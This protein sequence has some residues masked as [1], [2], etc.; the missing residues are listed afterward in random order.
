MIIE[1]PAVEVVVPQSSLN[2]FEVHSKIV[3]AV[4]SYQLP[5]VSRQLPKAVLSS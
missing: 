4:T 1:E 3:T 2:G 5:V